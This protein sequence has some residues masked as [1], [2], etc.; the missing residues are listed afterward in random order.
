MAEDKQP[1]QPQASGN[2]S[3]ILRETA[4]SAI[5][6]DGPDAISYVKEAFRWQYNWIGLGGALAFAVISGTGL[7][8][9]LAAGLEL[10]YLSMV[11]QS[12]RF[13]RLVRSWK[14]A[15]E[16]HEIQKKLQAMF[17]EIPPEMRQRYA[18]VDAVSRAIRE[19]YGRLSSTSQMFVKQMEERLDGLLQGYLRLLHAAHQHQEY[20]R[21]TDPETIK[22]E[23]AQLERA[24]PSDA[25]K[26]QD[27][28]RKR[29]E[30]LTKRLEKFDKIRENAQVIDAQC[31]AIEDVLALIRDQSVTLRDPQQV[32]D[33]LDNLVRDVEQTEQTVRE[34]EAIFEM[35]TPDTLL[36]PLP[37]DPDATRSSTRSRVRN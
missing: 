10:I 34:V 20:L 18:S 3:S 8:V 31:A 22:T 25:A 36:G 5:T 21:N 2:F 15:E 13:R 12:S 28:N 32:N 6:G 1:G 27:I 29:V 24:L 37:A 7:P 14:Y 35:A 19:N 4:G 9:L 26:V 30:I 16:K 23:V 11:P 17:L 33:Q